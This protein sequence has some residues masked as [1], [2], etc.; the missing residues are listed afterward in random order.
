MKPFE[1]KVSSKYGAPMG[2]PSDHYIEGKL[3]LQ[4]V[5]MYD[6]CYDKG[7]A[8]WGA[9]DFRNGIGY[10]YCAWNDDYVY[11]LR[12]NSRDDAKNQIQKEFE[13]GFNYGDISFYR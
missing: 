9:S 13:G 5:P 10:L 7:G 12:A 8:Y 6:G 2:R 11:Y 1:V 4:R 3:H